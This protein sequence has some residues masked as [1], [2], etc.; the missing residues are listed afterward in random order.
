VLV[1]TD[2]LSINFT[3]I[4]NNPTSVALLKTEI[5]WPSDKEIK[6]RNPPG[7][8]LSEGEFDIQ[9]CSQVCISQIHLT[10]RINILVN[11]MHHIVVPMLIC[12]CSNTQEATCAHLSYSLVAWIFYN[13]PGYFTIRNVL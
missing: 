12:S 3:D 2:E 1:I 10:H 11:V 7:N 4:K 5:A 8:N 13:L 9:S 6:F